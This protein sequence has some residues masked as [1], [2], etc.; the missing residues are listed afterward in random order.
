M[1]DERNIPIAKV[2]NLIKI[3]LIFCSYISKAHDRSIL[4]DED[5]AFF[6]HRR[7]YC[8]CIWHNRV[9][10]SSQKIQLKLFLVISL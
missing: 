1:K 10:M 5:M 6:K 3:L 2:D 7:F 9:M 4:C 8:E